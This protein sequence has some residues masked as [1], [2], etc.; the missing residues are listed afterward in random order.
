MQ[1]IVA[2]T[3]RSRF[4]EILMC[5]PNINSMSDEDMRRAMRQ[6]MDD[7]DADGVLDPIVYGDDYEG[8]FG[9]DLD[10]MSEIEFD[11]S[12]TEAEKAIAIEFLQKPKEE[13][14]DSNEEIITLESLKRIREVRRRL[15]E[16]PESGIILDDD[17]YEPDEGDPNREVAMPNSYGRSPLHEAIGMRN[18]DSIKKFIEEKKYLDVRDNNGNTPYQMAYQEGYM[19]AVE[20]FASANVAA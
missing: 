12:R 17:D 4:I 2:K 3:L 7:L 15:A 6:I 8:D 19:E 13:Q 18:L 1:T 16:N 11:E 9:D 10:T 20:V 5:N 14:R